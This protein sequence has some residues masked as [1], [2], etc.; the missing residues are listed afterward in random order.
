MTC[1]N[2]VRSRRTAAAGSH[3]HKN[4]PYALLPGG[5]FWSPGWPVSCWVR[6]GSSHLLHNTQSGVALNWCKPVRRGAIS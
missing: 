2:S 4:S 3:R 1:P 6:A 5:A